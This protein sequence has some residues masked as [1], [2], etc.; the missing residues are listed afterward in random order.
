ML[1]NHYKI[2]QRMIVLSIVVLK[3]ENIIFA[4]H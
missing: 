2:L 1:E 3:I 4:N